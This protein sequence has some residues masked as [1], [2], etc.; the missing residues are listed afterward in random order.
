MLGGIRDV[1]R[2]FRRWTES[3]KGEREIEQ[4]FVR[5]RRRWTQIADAVSEVYDRYRQLRREG[6]KPFDA[7]VEAL[8][9]AFSR[10]LPKI[11]NAVARQVPEIVKAF[12]SGFL[13]ADA[14][15][16]LIIGGWLIAKLGGAA[17]FLAIGRRLG[18]MLGLGI[19]QGAAAAVGGG[20]A[21]GG[22]G[23]AAAGG[24]AGG[25]LG[26]F[27]QL[28]RL[29]RATMIGVGVALGADLM[30]GI[31]RRI[32]GG[33]DSM[34]KA[35]K[36]A[37]EPESWLGLNRENMPIP[38]AGIDDASGATR[39]AEAAGRLERALRRIANAAASISPKRA[40]ELRQ[41]IDKLQGVSAPARRSMER[42][43]DTA[44]TR[45]K[46]GRQATKEW[47]VAISTM[48]RD[49]Q[50]KF[51]N[52]RTNVQFNTNLIREA[53]KDNS[54]R[55]REALAKNMQGILEVIRRTMRRGGKVT[56]EGLGL[57]KSLYVSELRFY[58]LSP[59]EAIAGANV[60]AGEVPGG[61]RRQDFLSGQASGG[62]AG[63]PAER[64]GGEPY[65]RGGFTGWVGRMGERGRDLV[66]AILGRGEAV[67]NSA[68]QKIVNAALAMTGI[69]GLPGLFNMTRG[70]KHHMA[71]GGI[72]GSAGGKQS[73]GFLE[74]LHPFNDP[75]GHGGGNSHLHIAMRSIPALI[76]LGRWLQRH[77][78]MVGE[79]PAFG[80]IQGAHD[81]QGFHYTNQAIDV[82]WPNAGQE[83]SMIRRLLPMLGQ[84]GG[85]AAEKLKRVVV[86]GRNSPLKGTVQRVLDL[87]RRSAQRRL[88]EAASVSATPGSI[89]LTGGPVPRQI[90]EFMQARRFSDPQ[91]GGWLGVLQKESGFST[92]IGNLAGSGAT[93]LAQWMGDRLTALKSKPNWTSLRTQLNFIWEEL[94]GSENAAYHAIKA[95]STPEAAAYA[96]DSQYERSDNI[97]NAPQLA[98]SWFEKFQG[99]SEGGIA[100]IPF[101][102][103]FQG[104]GFTGSKFRLPPE[105]AVRPSGLL[106]GEG[107]G[108]LRSANT[109]ITRIKGSIDDLVDDYAL[110]N[111][112]FDLTDEEFII[113]GTETT[114]P[115]LNQAA[116]SQRLAELQELMRIR[117]RIIDKYNRL[118]QYIRNMIIVYERV[119]RRLA[120]S[121]N[122]A[123]AALERLQGR[124]GREAREA[125]RTIG[126]RLD[127]YRGAFRGAGEQLDILR[128]DL[129]DASFNLESARIDLEE[130]KLE[131]QPLGGGGAGLTLPDWEPAGQ[132][133]DQAAI[134]TRERERAD[135][136]TAEADSLRTALRVFA[137]SGDIGSGGFTTRQAVV[138][139]TGMV[140]PGYTVGPGGQLIPVVSPAERA[141]KEAG[142]SYTFV[143]PSSVP[144]TREQ[145]YEVGKMAVAGI[146]QQ[147]PRIAQVEEV[148][149]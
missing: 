5:W 63:R 109:T 10:A 12:V 106:A 130:L 68:Q 95:T 108:W 97:L 41:E 83:A 138:S 99:M 101:V 98:R 79:H 127:R 118:V 9:E 58:G 25:L 42:L 33:S 131:A 133:E 24:A 51:A 104:G 114:P 40:Q 102:G 45:F 105:G 126:E 140:G 61:F 90:W 103:A 135:A 128:P 91:A 70:T 21:A 110:K 37:Q 136:A 122:R 46:D 75:A 52:M 16:Q 28:P 85:A 13:R 84:V 8:A 20:A 92:T 32:G 113:E 67:L 14:W 137:G 11:A 50:G 123:Q 76:R 73:G 62:Y 19:G 119:Q 30:Q 23:G 143:F 89:D 146:E 148:K 116:I 2:E 74:I 93:G 44:E 71:E 111:R 139:P 36:E 17:A 7:A 53:L 4:Y 80:G 96:I 65:A 27:K 26:R 34:F 141:A 47:Q 38:F 64:Y 59:K 72:A 6:E 88:N 43:V 132:T 29:M 115:S 54:G 69:R 117:Q 149:L 18:A 120:G 144:Y 56:D 94:M 55:G 66:H 142:N 86:R 134:A 60:R 129:D 87:T 145:A 77:G 48:V 112:R 3:V 49:S 39:S 107:R 15:G 82:N 35:L 81:P 31:Q 147:A 121:I 57:I 1:A 124:P 22:V 100:G 78:W 125:R